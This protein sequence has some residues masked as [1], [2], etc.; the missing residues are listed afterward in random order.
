MYY[1][2]AGLGRV[3]SIIV[4]VVIIKWNVKVMAPP[5]STYYYMASI[6]YLN[7]YI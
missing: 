1:M 4:Y 7:S 6:L 5:L 2:Q 3:Y